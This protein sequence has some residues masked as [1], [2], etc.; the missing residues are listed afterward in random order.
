MRIEGDMKM[1]LRECPDCTHRISVTAMSC[2]VCGWVI[3]IEQDT[4]SK[5]SVGEKATKV[6]SLIGATALVLALG[7]AAVAGAMA[8]LVVPSGVKIKGVRKK[9]KEINAIDIFT[10]SDNEVALVTDK[11]IWIGD[12]RDRGRE[13]PLEELTNV[14]IDGAKIKRKGRFRSASATITLTYKCRKLL[15]KFFYAPNEYIN[16][17]DNAIEIVKYAY[18]KIREYAYRVNDRK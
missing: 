10:L 5:S 7:P 6:G 18:E 15:G 1:K 17:G 13:V 9:A 8:S 16:T 14:E 4:S 12:G 11:A 2:P 3:P